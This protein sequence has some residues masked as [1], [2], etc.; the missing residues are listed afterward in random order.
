MIMLQ[1]PT[2]RSLL[3]LGLAG[4]G[5]VTSL[6][7]GGATPSLPAA[8]AP[9]RVELAPE[10]E[11][12]P[13]LATSAEIGAL[14]EQA[15]EQSFRASMDGLE[16]CLS[17]GLQRVAFLG[18]SIE[19]A[20]KVDAKRNPP[21]VWA[22]QST[23]GERTTEKCMFEAL[24]AVPWPKPIGGASGIARNSF[25]FEPRKG[26]PAPAV[27]DAGRVGEV[28]GELEPSLATCR[29]E[30]P[31]ALLVTLY[32]GEDGRA[33]SGGVSSAE[34]VKEEAVDCVMETLLA[35]QFPLPEHSPT[36]V[37]FPL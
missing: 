10:P 33:L 2:R 15:A 23:L 22:A 11:G 25:E 37:R 32:I 9:E 29:A 35:A 30:D 18:G 5:L 34:A 4:V 14:D 31:G 24:R 17:Q 7:C 36:K 16:E 21:R 13:E 28:L 20:V 6:G 12:E 27:W 8:E 26:T 3:G 19:F 1:G